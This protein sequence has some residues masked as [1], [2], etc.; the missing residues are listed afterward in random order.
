MAYRQVDATIS[1][2]KGKAVTN[3]DATVIE[4]T[5]GLYTGSG[6]DIKV[7]FALQTDAEAVVLSGVAGG[8]VL[9]VQ[10]TKVWATGTVATGIVAFY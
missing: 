1:A 8:I 10:V 3:S 5:R 6:G 2:S 9:P 4:C 7:T